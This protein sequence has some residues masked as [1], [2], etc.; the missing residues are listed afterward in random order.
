MSLRRPKFFQKLKVALVSR[1]GTPRS[2]SP[3]ESTS[4]KQRPLVGRSAITGQEAYDTTA[5]NPT[6]D[7]PLDTEST[8]AL[9][10]HTRQIPSNG[11]SAHVVNNHPSTS[12]DGGGSADEQPE[13]VLENNHSLAETARRRDLWEEAYKRLAREKFGLVA[14]YEKILAIEEHEERRPRETVQNIHEHALKPGITHSRTRLAALAKG[15][16]ASLDESRLEVQLG[17]RTVKVKD[18]VDHIITII[19]AAKDAVSG[20][21]ASEPHAALA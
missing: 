2:R 9:S 3:A 12:Q 5:S 4:S 1:T 10:P 17:S 19:I 11:S 20:A 7:A 18:G 21:V 13:H 16:L 15:K 6:L 8:S 14:Q